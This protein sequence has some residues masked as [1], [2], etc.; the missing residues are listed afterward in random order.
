VLLKTFI[1][2]TPMNVFDFIYLHENKLSW[3]TTLKHLKLEKDKVL[4]ITK[5]CVHSS[6]YLTNPLKY[7]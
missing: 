1:N 2:E 7:F 4:D 5:T 6:P 3:D